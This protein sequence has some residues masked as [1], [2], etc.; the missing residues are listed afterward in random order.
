M[1]PEAADARLI[2]N[3]LQRTFRAGPNEVEQLSWRA[4]EGI[5]PANQ[6]TRLEY[7]NV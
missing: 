5:Q 6:L 2:A 1:L 3:D 7:S 4:A